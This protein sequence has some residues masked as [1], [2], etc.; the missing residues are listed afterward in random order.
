MQTPEEDFAEESEEDNSEEI[1]DILQIPKKNFAEK[2]KEKDNEA[3]KD[4]MQ[5][6]QYQNIFHDLKLDREVVDLTGSDVDQQSNYAS[7][8]ADTGQQQQEPSFGN[9][10]NDRRVQLLDEHLD[11]LLPIRTNVAAQRYQRLNSTYCEDLRDLGIANPREV[12]PSV[13]QN[14]LIEILCD[15]SRSST[16]LEMA[17]QLL[18]DKNKDIMDVYVRAHTFLE[19][20]VK[21][22]SDLCSGV[23][24]TNDELL[25]SLVQI[26]GISL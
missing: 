2:S 24:K 25:R 12:H 8:D 5:H 20:C 10:T 6:K 1:K 9:T 15:R 18:R 11:K 17:G 16:C 26:R 7:D 21:T 13:I 19:D 14:H 23:P 22:R 4:K 3:I